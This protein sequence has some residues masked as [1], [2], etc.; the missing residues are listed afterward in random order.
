MST[1]QAIRAELSA[2]VSKE[3]GTRLRQ[4]LARIAKEAYVPQHSPQAYLEFL[5]RHAGH[6]ERMG[7]QASNFPYVWGFFSVVSQ[8]VYGDCIEECL[9]QAIAREKTP[10]VENWKGEGGPADERVRQILKD[11]IYG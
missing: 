3:T 7:P 9:D 10:A 6:F 8:H 1:P 11:A 4:E 2:F 5:N